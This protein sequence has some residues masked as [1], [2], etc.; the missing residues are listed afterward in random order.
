MPSR[1]VL[2]G[3]Q[4]ALSL[5]DYESVPPK[6]AQIQVLL[7]ATSLSPLDWKRISFPHGEKP[8]NTNP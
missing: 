7:K 3:P 6:D 8:K 2:L 1:T 5:V 4:E